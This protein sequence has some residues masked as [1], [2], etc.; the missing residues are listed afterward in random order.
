MTK[1]TLTF[2]LEGEVA[3][4]D[5]ASAM[6]NLNSMIV[7]LS[8][9]V[10]NNSDIEWVVEE[11]YP[12]SA[13]VTFAG[14][15]SDPMQ[16][17]RVIDA[18]EQ[19]GDSI[20]SGKQ[21]P[22]SEPVRRSA[23]AITKVINHKITAVRFETQDH[24]YQISAKFEKGKDVHTKYTYGSVKGTI[25]TL[26]NHKTLNFTLYDSLFNYPVHCYFK[27]GEE[28][29]M[30]GVWGRRAVVSGRIGRQSGT[31]RPLVI[32]E[33]KNVRALE[34]VEPGSYRQARGSIPWGPGETPEEIMRR[35]R[36]E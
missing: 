11:L 35:L 23:E 33:V 31:G 9:E 25:E 26:S 28:D 8:K 14:V 36:N 4:R 3:L 5:F 24:D 20:S 22:F 7:A 27:E 1:N 21:I 34:E 29:Q 13:T 19:V 30:R 17:V 18:Y 15:F 16:V 10:A 12:G 6:G 2:S 32:R